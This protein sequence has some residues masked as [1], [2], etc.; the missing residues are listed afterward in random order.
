MVNNEFY[1]MST[2]YKNETFLWWKMEVKIYLVLILEFS[3]EGTQATMPQLTGSFGR[4][5]V[6]G[7]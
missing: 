6:G 2:N 5:E 1:L 3:K 4:G 7:R